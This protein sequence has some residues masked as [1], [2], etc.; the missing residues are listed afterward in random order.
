MDTDG[1]LAD[2]GEPNQDPNSEEEQDSSDDNQ[3]DDHGDNDDE[4]GYG[5]DHT[6]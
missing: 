6:D 5:S 3:G 1:E 2:G 4:P